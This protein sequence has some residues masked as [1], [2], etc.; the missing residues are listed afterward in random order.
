MSEAST[1][2]TET[3]P[4]SEDTSG[5]TETTETKDDADNP[6]LKALHSERSTVKELKAQL[7]KMES[8]SEKRRMESLSE[9]ERAIEEA[10]KSGYESA[11]AEMKADVTK[12][13]VTAAAAAAG[14]ADPADAGGFLD[15]A[16]LESDADVK[17]AIDALAKAKPYLLKR[18]Q[19]NLEQGPQG[20]DPKQSPSDWLRKAMS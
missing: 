1:E 10:R 16:A 6:L 18:T 9:A 15:I 4:A 20:G 2:T 11:L 5:A 19:V 7:A 12:S 3:P 13:K 8:E 17:A 14:F